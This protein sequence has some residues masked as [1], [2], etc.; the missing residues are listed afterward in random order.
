M[1]YCINRMSLGVDRESGA[2]DRVDE[3]MMGTE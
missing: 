1:G 2:F 3:G